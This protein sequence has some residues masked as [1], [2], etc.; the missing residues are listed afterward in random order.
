[1]PSPRGDVR[2][3]I[4]VRPGEGYTAG[5][6]YGY[7]AVETNSLASPFRKKK[8]HSD[9]VNFRLCLCVFYAGLRVLRKIT[10]E[11]RSFA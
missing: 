9:G 10:E 7:L 11:N 2:L 3:F 6:P 5:A 4:V 8:T 1:M